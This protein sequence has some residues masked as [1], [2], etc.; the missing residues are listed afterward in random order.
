MGAGAPHA[1]PGQGFMEAGGH[2]V[3]ALRRVGPGAG[4]AGSP[5]VSEA[6]SRLPPDQAGV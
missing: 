3:L 1:A 4:Q 2:E 5:C 6:C